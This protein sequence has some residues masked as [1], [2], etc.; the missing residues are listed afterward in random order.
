MEGKTKKPFYKKW[1]I[2]LITA[3]LLGAIINFGELEETPQAQPEAPKVQV[4][5]ADEKADKEKFKGKETKQKESEK[6]TETPKEEVKKEEVEVV[7]ISARDLYTAYEDNEV[8]A[9]LNYKGKQIEVTGTV[10]DI[11]K[12]IADRMY[13]IFDTDVVLGGI[14][15]YFPKS[16]AES[17]AKINKGEQ[18][19]I[20]G[21]GDGLAVF[22]VSIKKAQIKD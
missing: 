9:D 5:A 22:T 17:V 14:Q 6:P 12:D 10:K 19:T 7:A 15:V 18:V 21:K 8:A 13:I 16:E 3:A 2:W 11:G 1:W 4:A 20:V